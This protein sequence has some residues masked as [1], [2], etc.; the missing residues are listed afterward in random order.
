M[1]VTA[2]I[3][4]RGRLPH[5]PEIPAH[6]PPELVMEP[7]ELDY[8]NTFVEPF[9]LTEIAMSELPPLFYSPAPRPGAS[10]PHWVVTR[11]ED[12]R[13]VYDHPQLYST[14]DTASFNRLVGETYPMIPLGTDGL[15]HVKYRAFLN[16]QFSPRAIAQMEDR[17]RVAIDE[18]IDGFKDKGACDAAYDFGRIYP[19]TVFLNLMGFP[20]EK[21]DEFLSWEYALLHSRGDLEKMQWGMGSAIKWL[22]GF[23]QETRDKEPDDTLGSFIV[24]GKIDGKPLTEDEIMG[25]MTF[26]WIGG[27]DT[28]AASTALMIRRLALYPELQQQ[29][30][31]NPDLINAAVE[32]FLRMGP[33][34]NSSRLVIQD[35]EIRGQ[36][37]KVGDW[38]VCRNDFGN[39]DPAQFDNPRKFRLDRKTNRHF[40][41]SGGPHLCLGMHLAR[42]ELRIAL[43]EFLS[44]IPQFR[45][46]SEVP[47]ETSPGLISAPNVPVVW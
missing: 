41:L 17:I 14:K 6:V 35:H 10:G 21:L 37:I 45:L 34:V 15:E 16:P 31:E 28:V 36:Q 38:V 2:K 5:E 42:R 46:A 27:L 30:R 29:L 13:F 25:M 39:F 3:K 22:R 7:Y 24:H 40:T 11:Y 44:R 32:E 20:Q 12:I 23:I 18:L 4:V 9:A 1:Q 8:M 47:P 43:G 33:I 19:V 26:L